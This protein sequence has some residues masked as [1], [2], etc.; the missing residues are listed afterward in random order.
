M[1][2]RV[3][4]WPTE[5]ELKEAEHRAPLVR[6]PRCGSDCELVAFGIVN[7]AEAAFEFEYDCDQPFDER[8]PWKDC[9]TWFKVRTDRDFRPVGLVEVGCFD[10][11]AQMYYHVPFEKVRKTRQSGKFKAFSKEE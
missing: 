5:G 2:D 11:G 10:Q 3:E 4:G 8:K 6:C 1:I 7:E 9:A